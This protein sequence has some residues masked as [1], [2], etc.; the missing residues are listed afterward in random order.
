MTSEILH[1]LYISFIFRAEGQTLIVCTGLYLY[2]VSPA[3]AGKMLK[4]ASVQK[5]III[6]PNSVFFGQG[7][8]QHA[9]L[10]GE[11]H[12]TVSIIST[13]SWGKII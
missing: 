2:V 12:M 10:D 13:S 7:C 3:K 11:G 5:K 1:P 6:P 4:N 8:M 9:G